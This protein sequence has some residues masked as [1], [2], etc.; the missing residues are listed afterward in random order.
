VASIVFGL[1][2][3]YYWYKASTAKGTPIKATDINPYVA[4]VREQS[5]L[6]KIAAIYTGL[7]V[8][9]QAAASIIPPNC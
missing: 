8:I 3:A 1:I 5:R 6:N 9:F 2:A 4:T 7:A